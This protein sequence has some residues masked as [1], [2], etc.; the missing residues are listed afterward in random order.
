MRIERGLHRAL[1]WLGKYICAWVVGQILAWWH[2]W[3]YLFTRESDRHWGMDHYRARPSWPFYYCHR[4][5]CTCG[6]VFF[7]A[8]D[9]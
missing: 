5:D 7:D 2:Q 3:R 4:S 9:I 8:D 6:E 1:P